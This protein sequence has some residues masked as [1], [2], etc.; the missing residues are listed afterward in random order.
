M[1]GMCV[2]LVCVCVKL[3]EGAGE[4]GTFTVSGRC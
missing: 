1:L 3:H 4:F 2:V